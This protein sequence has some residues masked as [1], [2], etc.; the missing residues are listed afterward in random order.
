MSQPIVH[1]K[2]QEHY[3][4]PLSYTYARKYRQMLTTPEEM[5]Q[6][7]QE[8]FESCRLSTVPKLPLVPVEKVENFDVV[9]VSLL[10]SS[11][12]ERYCQQKDSEVNSNLAAIYKN[13][14]W[15]NLPITSK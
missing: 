8:L 13:G 4:F 7:L 3:V 6:K 14:R 2:I 5:A 12:R 10:L 15:V 1:R 11:H 9:M